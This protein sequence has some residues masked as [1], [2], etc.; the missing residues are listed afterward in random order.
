MRELV[1]GYH[2]RRD[3]GY[4]RYVGSFGC[5]R[6]AR[7]DSFVNSGMHEMVAGERDQKHR[8]SKMTF[9]FR[10]SVSIMARGAR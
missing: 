5:P 8:E 7:G 1:D 9:L 10:L 3:S 6:R 4:G 2:G